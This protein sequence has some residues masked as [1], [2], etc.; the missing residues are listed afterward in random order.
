MEDDRQLA[1]DGDLGLLTLEKTVNLTKLAERS[2]EARSATSQ[3]ARI[4]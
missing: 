3:S 2:S 4:W 1:G